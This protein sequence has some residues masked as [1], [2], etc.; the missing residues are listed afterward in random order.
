MRLVLRVLE[1][2]QERAS[3]VRLVYVGSLQLGGCLVSFLFDGLGRLV[4]C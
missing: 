2:E 1:R 3:S 4:L